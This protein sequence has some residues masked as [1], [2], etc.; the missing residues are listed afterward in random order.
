MLLF[1]KKD[2][3]EL[4]WHLPHFL[5]FPCSPPVPMLCASFLLGFFYNFSPLSKVY[6]V[7][8]GRM[9]CLNNNFYFLQTFEYFRETTQLLEQHGS[10]NVKNGRVVL[11]QEKDVSFSANMWKPILTA[12]WVRLVRL[13]SSNNNFFLLG[14]VYIRLKTSLKNCLKV[15]FLTRKSICIMYMSSSMLSLIM[16][17]LF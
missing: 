7:Y 12:Y 9:Y 5:P 11:L 6:F 2:K 13:F 17:F 15:H 8:T 14:L 4:L 3:S 10:V 16:L 1:P